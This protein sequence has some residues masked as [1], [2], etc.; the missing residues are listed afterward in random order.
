MHTNQFGCIISLEH[1]QFFQRCWF[2]AQTLCLGIQKHLDH[3]CSN[4]S[5]VPLYCFHAEKR[6]CTNVWGL[7]VC[8]L[9]WALGW[10][11]AAAE[12]N[13]ERG[14]DIKAARW[15]RPTKVSSCPLCVCS[16]W[17]GLGVKFLGT[18]TTIGIIAWDVCG[19]LV[20]NLVLHDKKN[21]CVKIACTFECC[22][23][24][25][26]SPVFVC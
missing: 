11:L 5:S 3:V 12:R 21:G 17:H 9:V 22:C 19:V 16:V 6:L 7:C 24:L 2:E 8:G 13:S 10:V 25:L 14:E 1:F 20:A 26:N 4:K 23:W 15:E 18:N